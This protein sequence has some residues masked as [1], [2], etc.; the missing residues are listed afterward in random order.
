MTDANN[1]GHDSVQNIRER[2]M[3]YIRTM[4]AAAEALQIPLGLDLFPKSARSANDVMF[5]RFSSWFGQLFVDFQLPGYEVAE[6]SSMCD[7]SFDVVL[8]FSP[9][10]LYR[11]TQ[12]VRAVTQMLATAEKLSDNLYKFGFASISKMSTDAIDLSRATFW[13]SFR[14]R[15]ARPDSIAEMPQLAS[16]FVRRAVPKLYAIDGRL[17]PE[18]ALA[19]MT[20]PEREI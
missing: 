6:S 20:S 7:V 14:A 18:D 12:S 9:G 1:I 11:N 3:E 19:K 13:Y 16:A 17:T 8:R 4:R 2:R 15:A 5:L 10:E